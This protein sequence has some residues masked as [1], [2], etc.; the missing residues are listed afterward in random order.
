MQKVTKMFSSVRK[1]SFQCFQCKI[2]ISLSCCIL[3]ATAFLQVSA[4]DFKPLT[5][6]IHIRGRVFDTK[7]PPSPI[8]NVSV[9]IKNGL[10]GTSTDAD[11]NF[12][13]HAEKG[14]T[15]IFSNIGY[16]TTEYIIKDNR[17]NVSISLE[18]NVSVLNQVVVTGYTT[19][20][21]KHLASSISTLNVQN[22][23]EGKPIT[24]LS[25]ALQGG[26]TGLTVTQ[27]SGLPGGAD[28]ASIKVRGIS[29]LGNTAP[30]VLVDGVP[31]SIDNVD[32][33][34]VESIT[35]LKDAAAASIYGA[36]AANGVI[37]I[38]TKRGKAGQV[39]ISYQGYAGVQKPIYLPTFVGAP[40]FMQMTNEAYAN[41]GANPIYSDSDI[42]ITKAGT[43]PLGHPNTDWKKLV[44]NPNTFIQSHSIS[45]T[46]GSN[47][48]RFAV[49][50]TYFTQDGMIKNTSADKF[51]LRANTSVTL[52]PKLSMHV[53]LAVVRNENKSPIERYSH[54]PGG[55]AGY[56]FY[57]LFR[58]PPTIV[59]KYPVRSDGLQAYGNYSL[60]E[61]P[62][63]DL[64]RGG[65][66]QG[67]VDNVNVNFQP[68]WKIT[69]S[70]TFVGQYL[71][72]VNSSASILDD[73]TYNFLDYY[74]SALVY[75]FPTVKSSSV[76]RSTYQYL[77]ATLNYNK[78][79]NKNFI[80]AFGGVSREIRNPSNFDEASIASYFIKAN[81]AYDDKYLFEGTLRADGSSLFGPGQKWGTFPSVALGWN[82]SDEEFMRS[83]KFVNNL[84]L[85]SSYGLLGNNQ[86]VGLYQYENA[87]N[88]NGVETVFGNPNITW[89]TVKM[90]DIGAD[91]G[92]IDNKIRMSI[93]WYNKIT[94][95]ILLSPP[96]S[97]ASGLGSVPINAG[98]VQNK[99][100]EFSLKYNKQFTKNLQLSFDAGYSYYKNEILSLR[101]GPYININT[102]NKVGYPIGSYY[103]FKTDGLLQQSDIDKGVPVFA[104]EEAGDVKYVDVNK[105][106][107][108]TDSDK[109][110]LGNPD[111]QGN[112]F[113]N[114]RIDFKRIYFQVQVNGFT[115]SLGMYQ[116]QYTV[117]LN[118]TLGGG[119][120]MTWQT[121]TWTPTNTNA[122]YPRLL[123]NPSN[124]IFPSDF[125]SVNAA[126][127][128]IR[129][130]QLGYNFNSKLISKIGL[131]SADL[132]VNAQNPFTFSKMK[133]LDPESQGSEFTYPLLQFYTI[134][135]NIKFKQ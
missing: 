26:V 100:W 129:Y 32:P 53:D 23:I 4:K 121:D 35:V 132:Y 20:K 6:P 57:E 19:E 56:V 14:D 75:T 64:E 9:R 59:A 8:A 106:G 104:G 25:Q 2:I 118:Q 40:Q 21:V 61:N 125:W 96:L 112:Y 43:N 97:L 38:T 119:T 58:V 120:P 78:N 82:V 36:R 77:S 22:S 102:I 130:L 72:Q 134:G 88:G 69:P 3:L 29:T 85:R 10:I 70:L 135:I 28:A 108:L 86:N 110:V 54:G 27:S 18:E 131:S 51:S 122:K 114:V 33:A 52:N 30:L 133:H 68:Q 124:N 47:V 48:A 83:V 80:G 92:L 73:D 42:A 101:G 31:F 93:D 99:G 11:G 98:K 37:V 115:K 41:I 71:F 1:K 91:M 17:E 126:F 109:V 79:L 44:L 117:P 45:V 128:R 105:S 127:A 55:G 76:G 113:V 5:I 16:K 49:T 62:V 103:G 66:T 111:P 84:K 123:P 39:N 81:Y 65:F 7:D 90:W 60:M 12:E 94:D 67:K 34:T 50:G 63:A 13:L 107:S 74:T 87:I 89:E 95:N 15:L 24:Q 116:G 46:G